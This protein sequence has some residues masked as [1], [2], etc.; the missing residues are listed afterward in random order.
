MKFIICAV[1]HK[2]PQWVAAGFQEYAKRMPREA[3]IELLEIKPEKRAGMKVEQLLDVEANRILAALP[4]RCRLVAMDERGRQC[5]TV[6]FAESVA[7]WMRAGGDTVFIIGGAD[8]L[9]PAIKNAADEV[10]ALSTLTMPHAM[11]RIV[12]AEQLYRTVSLIKG[13]PYHRG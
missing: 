10:L 11:A 5:S 12:L 7:G 3:A 8:G 6:K 13:H 4:A 2:M 9:A 1:G